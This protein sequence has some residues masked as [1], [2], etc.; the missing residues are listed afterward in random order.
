MSNIRCKATRNN[1]AVGMNIYVMVYYRT[2]INTTLTNFADTI[3]I[4]AMPFGLITLT[5]VISS[6]ILNFRL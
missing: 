5:I 1:F 3:F 4:H 6:S 2:T